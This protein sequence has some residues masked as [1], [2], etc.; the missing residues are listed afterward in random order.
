MKTAG[1]EPMDDG[2]KHEDSIKFYLHQ[3]KEKTPK[4]IKANVQDID[5]VPTILNLAG[6]SNL[7]GNH[8]IMLNYNDWNSTALNEKS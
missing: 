5:I 1:L 3:Q 2:I 7:K 6:Q 8:G 4:T